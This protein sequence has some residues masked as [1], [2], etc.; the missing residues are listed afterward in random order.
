MTLTRREYIGAAGLV[1]VGA[2]AGCAGRAEPLEGVYLDEEP[3]YG[4]WFKGVST[5]TRTLDWRGEADITVRVGAQG[6]NGYYYLSPPAVAVSPGTEVTWEWTGKGGTHNVVASDRSF[7]SGPLVDRTG[8]TFTHTFDEPGVYTYYCGPHT[9][10]GMKGA[11]VVM[12]PDASMMPRRRGGIGGF[13]DW[14][15]GR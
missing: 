1:A 13:I 4:T 11:V 7:D 5:Y 9:S 10:L 12:A 2:L 6:A 15:F 3:D 14:L 8:H